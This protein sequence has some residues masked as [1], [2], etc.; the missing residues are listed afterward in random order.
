MTFAT[1]NLSDDC[2][3]SIGTQCGYHCDVG[4][5]KDPNVSLVT[6]LSFGVWDRNLLDLC[7]RKYSHYGRNCFHDQNMCPSA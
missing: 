7:T 2:N 5:S 6:C 3:P 1:G 4:Y